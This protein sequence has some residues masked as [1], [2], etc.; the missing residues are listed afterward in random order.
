VGVFKDESKK[1][2]KKTIV[3]LFA[4]LITAQPAQAQSKKSV[5]VTDR[6]RAEL[7][8]ILRPHR[9]RGKGVS[10][11][12]RAAAGD[13]NM[14]VLERRQIGQMSTCSFITYRGKRAMQCQS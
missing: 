2:K 5:T 11:G 9:W 1:M 14:A 4:A 6:D 13:P 10:R 3:L 8:K 12:V 7:Q